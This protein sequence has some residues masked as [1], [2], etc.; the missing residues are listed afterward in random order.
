MVLYL[1]WRVE[2]TLKGPVAVPELSPHGLTGPFNTRQL[3]CGLIKKTG[4]TL[5]ASMSQLLEIF[6]IIHI[7]I[8]LF[9]ENSKYRLCKPS[10][11]HFL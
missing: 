11:M 8:T 5:N 7:G 1:T 2:T 9:K 10:Y 3:Q 6:V 4:F